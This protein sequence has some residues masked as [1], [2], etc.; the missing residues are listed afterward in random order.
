MEQDL[1]S[2][3]LALVVEDEHE[4]RA[5]VA[6]ILEQ[7]GFHVLEAAD[8]AEGDRIW[9][10]HHGISLVLADI[11]LPGSTGIDMA[12]RFRFRKPDL[13]VLFMSAFK[14]RPTAKDMERMKAPS[15]AKPFTST[16]LMNAVRGVMKNPVAV[17]E[18]VP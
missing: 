4:L 16:E 14:P 10:T 15:I 9:A 3:P 1:D 13:N 5:L 11:W 2:K 18:M 12:E 17:G 6:C 8:A 7:N